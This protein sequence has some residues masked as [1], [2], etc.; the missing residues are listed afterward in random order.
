MTVYEQKSDPIT[1]SPTTKRETTSLKIT[2]P[3]SWGT[4]LLATWLVIWGMVILIAP[5]NVVLV[6]LSGIL[7]ITAGVLLFLGK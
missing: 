5:M 7:A 2:W 6:A 4:T 1:G 3:A